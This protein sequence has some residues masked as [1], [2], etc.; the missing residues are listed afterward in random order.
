MVDCWLWT[1]LWKHYIASTWSASN[2]CTRAQVVLLMNKERENMTNRLRWATRCVWRLKPR[3]AQHYLYYLKHTHNMS[4][5]GHLRNMCTAGI[6]ISPDIN[7]KRV[8]QNISDDTCVWDEVK[9]ESRAGTKSRRKA[10]DVPLHFPFSRKIVGIQMADNFNCE[11]N[12][13][14][15]W[16]KHRF[17]IL[18]CDS[19]QPILYFNLCWHKPT[20]SSDCWA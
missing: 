8:M 20:K 19:F 4:N 16:F 18:L 9:H 15:P 11:A 10:S 14:L 12:P 2:I 7:W 3:S 1:V 5:D 17:L 13:N 6:L